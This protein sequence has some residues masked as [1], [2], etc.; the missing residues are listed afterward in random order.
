[1]SDKN[2]P[3]Y[4][5]AQRLGYSTFSHAPN[6]SATYIKG[7]IALTVYLDGNAELHSQWKLVRLST[8]KIS[9][10]HPRFEMFERQLRELLAGVER[11]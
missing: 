3:G 4:E 1:M 11:T 10:P 6:H 8:G 2:H 9:F 5:E 7:E